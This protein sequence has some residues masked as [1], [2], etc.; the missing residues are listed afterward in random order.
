RYRSR[1]VGQP[2]AG[3]SSHLLEMGR[4]HQSH[5]QLEGRFEPFAGTGPEHARY[6]IATW[7]LHTV[8]E[9]VASSQ[10]IHRD[11]W[12]TSYKHRIGFKQ[13]SS[14]KHLS[15][16]LSRMLRT[17]RAM[18]ILPRS[19]PAIVV[20]LALTGD[21]GAQLL[22]CRGGQR[23]TQVAELMFGRKIGDRVGVGDDEWK[24]FIDREITPRFPDGLTIFDADSQWRDKASGKVVREPSKNV[25]IVLPRKVE[26]IP[27]PNPYAQ[28]HTSPSQHTT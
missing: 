1:N 18:K 6:A 28:A 11:G 16:S 20:A 25:Q 3:R 4:G 10:G 27:R 14:A 13:R 9:S 23:P 22:D 21:A 17:P 26:G 19:A 12:Q 5:L 15:R 7:T 8:R 24:S 2:A